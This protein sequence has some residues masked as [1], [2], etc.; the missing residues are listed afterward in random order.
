MWTPKQRQRFL[1]WNDDS[2]IMEASRGEKRT[3]DE[4]M[5][6]EPT[7][8]VGHGDERPFYIESVR[9]VNMKK[10]RTKAM[11]YP[12]QFTSALADVEITSLHERFHE[13]LQQVLDKTIGHVPPQNQVRFMLHF[14]Q[15]GISHHVAVHGT[16]SFNHRTHSC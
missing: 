7:E 2:Y 3:Y 11:S 5:G 15:F 16:W 4:M 6:K 1:D 12:V 10:F 14:N 8:Q 13:I 9:Q